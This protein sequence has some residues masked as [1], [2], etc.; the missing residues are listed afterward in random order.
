M[1]PFSRI[2]VLLAGAFPLA[3]RADVAPP[4][5]APDSLVI[6]DPRGAVTSV[7]AG[8]HRVASGGRVLVRAGVYREPSIT[9]DHPLTLQGEPGAILDGSGEHTVLIVAADDV[10]VRGLVLRNTGR[11]QSEQRAG[12]LVQ[13]ARGCRIENNRLEATLFAL[14]LAHVRDCVVR[15]NVVRG[16]GGAQT[17]T[18]SGIHIWSS[19]RVEVAENEVYGHRDGIYFEFV[20][21]GY[22][23][24]NR[25]EG[26]ARYGMH[27]MYSDDCRYE[28]NLYRSNSNGIAVMYSKRVFMSHNRFEDNWGSAAYGLLLKNISDSHVTDNEFRSNSIGLFM[29]D[30]NRNLVRG[31]RFRD[32]GWALKLMASAQDNTFEGNVF[33]SNT[34]DV[35]TNSRSNF[36]SFS[37]NFWDRYRGYDLD[38]DGVG[39]VP[40][41]PVRL[42]ALVVSQAPQTIILLRSLVVDLLDVA[43]RLLP[44]VTPAGLVDARPLMK[45]PASGG[46]DD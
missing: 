23:H 32:N 19:E 46:T 8:V 34:F 35:T 2:V 4:A 28:H 5:Q 45:R 33:E 40:H 43:E 38:R 30:S 31:N 14:Y 22:V 9:I 41:A 27:F 10:T 39:D 20:T 18:G 24:H 7:Q 37:G 3:V 42:F 36:S 21:H 16:A 44:S 6:V 26:S 15:G 12:I 25:T 1:T 13:E 11:S 29:E 17:L